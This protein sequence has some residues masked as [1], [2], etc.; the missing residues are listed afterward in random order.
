MKINIIAT[1][2][3]NLQDITFRALD[4]LRNSDC[5][6]CENKN[7][8]LTILRKYEIA[9]DDKMFIT[10]NDK[11][12]QETRNKIFS[13]KFERGVLVS[14]AGTP[15][16]SDPGYKLIREAI[17]RKIEVDFMPGPCAAIMGLVL[18][19]FST[20]KFLFLGFLPHKGVANYLK[21]YLDLEIT[22][23]IYE[24]VHRIE[25]TI[26]LIFEL[27][28]KAKIALVREGTKMFQEVLRFNKD[29]IP[30]IKKKGEFTLCISTSVNS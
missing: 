13:S 25:N 16:I 22:L 12:N 5:I 20:D 7:K 11:S 17:E 27:N 21:K 28:H 1:P 30:L 18:S 10:Y 9:Y 3:G 24:S 19:G 23:I 15:L 2:I 8:I 6:I 26:K 14:D 4:E 29:N